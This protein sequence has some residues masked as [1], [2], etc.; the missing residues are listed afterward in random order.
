MS[1]KYLN[2]WNVFIIITARIQRTREGNIFSLSTLAREGGT[3]SQ[4]WTRGVP[5]PRSRWGGGPH[6]ADRG[7]Y[8][9][10]GLNRGY[11]APGLDWG[12]PHSRSRQEI[13]HP[14]SEQRGTPSCWGGSPSQVWT[15]GGNPSQVQTG[16]TPSLVQTWGTP[17]PWSRLDGVPPC[18]GLDGVPPPPPIRRQI[19]KVSTCYTAGD[20]PLAFMQEDFLVRF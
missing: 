20:V 5:H 2:I 7:R 4:V 19:S 3:P 13:P 12:V 15:G 6:P 14:R 16:G 8:P 17:L 9:V 11:P 18:P 1:V 10:P